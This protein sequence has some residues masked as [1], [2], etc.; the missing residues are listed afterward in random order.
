MHLN[1]SVWRR[2]V[3]YRVA[4]SDLVDG[5]IHRLPPLRAAAYRRARRYVAGATL[6]EAVLTVRRLHDQGL[7][8]SLD[9]FGEDALTAEE[10]ARIVRGYEQAASAFSDL[11]ASV[12]LEVVPSH[13]GLALGA[14][15]WLT[16]ANRIV[17]A[18]PSGAR[19]QVSA[20]E[21]WRVP[22]VV[23]LTETLVRGGAP[24][25]ATVQANL[26]RSLADA[27][28]LAA[29]GAAIR[30]VKGAYPGPS[31]QVLAWGEQTDDAFR[32]IARRLGLSGARMSLG[33]HD[34]LLREE[35]L[36]ELP[37]VEVEMLLGVRPEDA[38]DL[39][40]RRRRVRIYVPYG[41]QWVRY[42]LRRVAEA[43]RA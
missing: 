6:E 29:A 31:D 34:P 7:A 15:A 37:A 14:T 2:G 42:W 16:A 12:D 35:L 39:V 26:R 38:A 36:E 1:L 22:A 32:V 13:L 8:C 25:V 20:E 30:L 21:H 11:G 18:L 17:A 3:L 43:Q 40:R 10:V 23:E 9:L 24:V 5:A 28:R 19:L 4:T 41:D 27:E 33:T